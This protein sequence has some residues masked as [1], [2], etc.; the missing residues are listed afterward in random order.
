M[1]R[2]RVALFALVLVTVGL[3]GPATAASGVVIDYSRMANSTSLSNSWGYHKPYISGGTLTIPFVAGHTRNAGIVVGPA[4]TY[5]RIEIVMRADATNFKICPNLWPAS[6]SGYEYDIAEGRY[7]TAPTQTL[8]YGGSMIHRSL[9]L[10]G[11]GLSSWTTIVVTWSRGHIATYINGV[12]SVIDDS[13]VPNIPMKL[14]LQVG[15][16]HGGS[17]QSGVM[18]VRSVKIWP[19]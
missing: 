19:G 17:E 12:A 3:A 11:S 15:Q 18:Q 10:S 6:G 5:G 14:H 9:Q 13:H 16:P 7:R 1:Q 4:F 2:L 8:H